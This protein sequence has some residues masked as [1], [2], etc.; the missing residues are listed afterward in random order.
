MGEAMHLIQWTKAFDTGNAVIDSQHRELIECLNEMM[1]SVSEGKGGKVYAACK[2]LQGLLDAHFE[3]EEAILRDADFP[4]LSG[5]AAS[6]AV[7]TE[8]F[9]LVCATCGEACKD[10]RAG[11]CIPDMTFLLFDHFVRGDLLFKSF[12]QVKGLAS[13]NDRPS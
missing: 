1:T 5:H 3:D 2:K 11:P 10:N 13:G 7:T 9:N 12:L 4:D 6:H 8:R